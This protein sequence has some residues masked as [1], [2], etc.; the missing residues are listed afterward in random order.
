MPTQKT[1]NFRSFAATRRF[2]PGISQC[3]YMVI[4]QN[5]GRID[6]FRGQRS[7]GL[8]CAQNFY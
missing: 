7:C 8:I 4:L 5:T 6:R 1:K 3:D 2:V